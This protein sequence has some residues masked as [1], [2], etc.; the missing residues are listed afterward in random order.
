MAQ[1]MGLLVKTQVERVRIIRLTAGQYNLLRSFTESSLRNY[2][3]RTALE[4]PDRFEWKKEGKWTLTVFKNVKAEEA[5]EL[6]VRGIFKVTS[7]ITPFAVL[8][9]G[10]EVWFIVLHNMDVG[11]VLRVG[12]VMLA[13]TR[14]APIAFTGSVPFARP[15]S[16]REVLDTLN[17]Y[18]SF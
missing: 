11:L 9:N 6:P 13:F 18:V 5:L 3:W 12:G 8:S 1:E 10:N 14:D 2:P 17:H 4:Y 16:V 15:I 7:N